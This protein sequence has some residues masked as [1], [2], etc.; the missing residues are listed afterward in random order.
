[1][2][3]KHPRP[4]HN[5]PLPRGALALM[6]FGG[7]SLVACGGTTSADVTA[8]EATGASTPAES[9]G[10][11]PSDAK[12]AKAPGSTGG[13]AAIATTTKPDD[14]RDPIL[15]SGKPVTIAFAGDMNFEGPTGSRLDADPAS[16]FG[17]VTDILSS[18]DLTVA[19]L[20]TA[21]TKGGGSPVGKQFTFSTGPR[22]FDAIK[23]AGID[24]VS[25]ANNHGM[26]YGESGFAESLQVRDEVGFPIIGMGAND[27]EA[28]AP[29]IAEVNGQRLAVIAATQVL[30]GS[31]IQSWT[32]TADHAGLASAK[33]EDRLVQA[34]SEARKKADTV[35]VFLHWG[36]ETQTCPNEAQQSL[37]P[38]LT[39][40]GADIVVGGHAHRVMSGGFSGAA[41]VGYGLGNFLF[42]A[43]SDL[44][45]RS[46]V[47]KVT[48]TGRQI[49][50]YEWVPALINGA[51]QPIPA[52]AAAAQNLTAS[53]NELRGCTGLTDA[54]TAE[55]QP[56]S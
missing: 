26:D 34:V 12:T 24:V 17:P 23:A 30:D 1:M 44:G 4:A 39:A 36:T 55:P 25:M 21:V 35:I 20:E 53:W 14:G 54:A 28:F 45:R 42:Q 18:A 56:A 32:A 9:A 47:L 6:L 41:F 43:N 31:F 40:A 16:V 19:N 51:N 11:T 8:S 33:R 50:N 38:K 49:D 52:D 13:E 15:G 46:G 7:L 48:A 5:P 22:A 27:A 3:F 2:A 37:T 10:A 29:H